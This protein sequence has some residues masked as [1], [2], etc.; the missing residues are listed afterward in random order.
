M[1]LFDLARCDVKKRGLEGADC[2][3]NHKRHRVEWTHEKD[4]LL[5]NILL[6]GEQSNESQIADYH[7]KKGGPQI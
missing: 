1:N 6:N 7:I 3:R 4:V 5:E 2:R